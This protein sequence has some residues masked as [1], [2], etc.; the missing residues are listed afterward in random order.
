M[1]REAVHLAPSCGFRRFFGKGNVVVNLVFLALGIE[2]ASIGLV[3]RCPY[4]TVKR[5]ISHGEADANSSQAE[6]HVNEQSTGNKKAGGTRF[7]V[8][9]MSA[10]S[11]GFART[12]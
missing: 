2:I 6:H 3:F 10:L 7:F 8:T 1:G 4:L 9:A 5:W 12:V 11:L